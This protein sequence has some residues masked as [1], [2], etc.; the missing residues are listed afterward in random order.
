MIEAKNV[1]LLDTNGSLWYQPTASYHGIF[2]LQY[3]CRD[4]N[5]TSR[6]TPIT[7]RIA[8]APYLNCEAEILTN[9]SITLTTQDLS[10]EKLWLK[11][12]TPPQGGNLT[13]LRSEDAT[14]VKYDQVF[15]KILFVMWRHTL[16]PIGLGCPRIR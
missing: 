16:L 8:V 15:K 14:P 10:K 6:T 3:Y 11:I 7:V 13:S 9:D 2:R 1:P 5:G 4:K 12:S